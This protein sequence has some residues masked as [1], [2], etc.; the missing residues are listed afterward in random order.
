MEELAFK[1]SESLGRHQPESAAD[2]GVMLKVGREGA[3]FVYGTWTGAR[4]ERLASV[5][6][7]PWKPE[8]YPELTSSGTCF[9]SR[10]G[11]QVNSR[12]QYQ[13]CSQSYWQ[14]KIC[15]HDWLRKS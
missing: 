15:D 10:R 1:M 6:A 9:A 2:W 12:L 11:L 3:L 5:R 7:L 13:S 4:K 8:T 14:V